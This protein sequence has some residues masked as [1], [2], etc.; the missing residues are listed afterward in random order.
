MLGKDQPV[1]LHLLD[2]PQ[3]EGNLKGVEME[4]RDCS[5]PTLADIKTTS[6]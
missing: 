1:I 4:L 2:I 3:M 6:S 5:F